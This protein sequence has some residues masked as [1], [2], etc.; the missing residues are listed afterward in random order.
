MAVL[1]DCVVAGGGPGV[2]RFARA[3]SSYAEELGKG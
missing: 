3:L 2:Q 1:L